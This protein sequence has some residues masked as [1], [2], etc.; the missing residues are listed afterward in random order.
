M[1]L[2]LLTTFH[3]RENF[4]TDS[5]LGPVGTEAG[6]AAQDVIYQAVYLSHSQV[7]A[8]LR[9][10]K[11]MAIVMAEKQL[12][13]FPNEPMKDEQ[14]K[15]LEEGKKRMLES[16]EEGIKRIEAETGLDGESLRRLGKKYVNVLIKKLK[17]G[18]KPS[19]KFLSKQYDNFV[20][21]F[22][23]KIDEAK[24]LP[25]VEENLKEVEAMVMRDARQARSPINRRRD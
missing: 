20:K 22:C 17:S 12:N 10:K 21:A 8:I 9:S 6:K 1:I 11:D 19:K 18:K 25:V 16:G 5:E 15:N 4:E 2:L 7:C 23:E 14:L 24:L 3:K 13:G